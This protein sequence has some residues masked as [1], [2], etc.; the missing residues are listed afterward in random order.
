MASTAWQRNTPRKDR[1]SQAWK[2]ARRRALERDTHQCTALDHDVRCTSQA[3][4]VDHIDQSNN[5][6][7]NNLASLCSHHHKIKTQIEAAQARW[8]HRQQRTPEKH[9]GLT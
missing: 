4:E 8:R 7:L 3:V 9:P 2:Q 6:E 1:S 5:H